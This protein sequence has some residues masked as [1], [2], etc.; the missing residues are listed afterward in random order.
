MNIQNWTTFLG[1]CAD[2][3]GNL[4]AHVSTIYTAVT[5]K[6]PMRLSFFVVAILGAVMAWYATQSD[7][8]LAAK[9]IATLQFEYGNRFLCLV[10]LYIA[11]RVINSEMRSHD[12]LTAAKDNKA[13]P[14]Y[15]AWCATWVLSCALIIAFVS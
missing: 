4:F 1:W 14:V 3:C 6:L 12:L 7:H 5:S 15:V 11:H 8:P 9:W 10:M 2:K 13:S